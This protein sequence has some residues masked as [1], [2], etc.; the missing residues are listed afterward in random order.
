VALRGDMNDAD[1]HGTH[2]QGTLAGEQ[3]GAFGTGSCERMRQG[4]D[5]SETWRCGTTRACPGLLL[6]IGASADEGIQMRA[7]PRLLL[8]IGAPADE[9]IQMGAYG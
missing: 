4:K 5:S 3:G 6:L 2:T 1:G 9:G 8:L 7:Y